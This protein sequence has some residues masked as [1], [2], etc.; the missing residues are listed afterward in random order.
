MAGTPFSP[1][2]IWR[3]AL[4]DSAPI[5]GA[6]SLASA[7]A[8]QCRAT[9]TSSPLSG[10]WV[11]PFNTGTNQSAFSVPVWVVGGGVTTQKVTLVGAS[12]PS[13]QAAW[14]A[15]PL[16]PGQAQ[17][18]ASGS[19]KDCVVWRPSTDEL[20]EFYGFIDLNT[21]IVPNGPSA[22]WGGYIPHVSRHPGY[23]KATPETDNVSWGIRAAGFSAL[24]GL[25]RLDELAAG[26]IPHAL[27]CSLALTGGTVSP[28]QRSDT[29][30]NLSGSPSVLAANR[31]P[32][33]SLF[34]F[35]PGATPGGLSVPA[36][37]L[38]A[39]I[40]DYGLYVGD[41]SGDMTLYI[42]DLRPLSTGYTDSAT[43]TNPSTTPGPADV[44]S[45]PWESVQ[46]VQWASPV[47]AGK[48][49][50]HYQGSVA[51]ISAY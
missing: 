10:P 30:T 51:L 40:R 25:I 21:S 44:Q 26:V 24:G 5:V 1:R 47:P 11:A 38:Y 18:E 3:T 2:S 41:S 34:R 45:L 43:L 14:N 39:A 29:Y 23:F 16:P 36:Q 7:L 6:G 4:A 17:L 8:A 49:L 20:W 42:E 48:K 37:I 12:A 13:L 9:T 31:I 27:V 28:A 50:C 19:D 15:V 35:P 46:Q 33:G 22:T 32:E